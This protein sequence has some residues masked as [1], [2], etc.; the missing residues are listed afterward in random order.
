MLRP[1]NGAAVRGTIKVWL[2]VAASVAAGAWAA[3][4]VYNTGKALAEVSAQKDINGPVEW[5]ADRCRTT[6]FPGYFVASV[7][8]AVL[9]LAMPFALGLNRPGSVKPI[10]WDDQRWQWRRVSV[11]DMVVGFGWAAAP[12][13]VLGAFYSG[14]HWRP[15][16]AWMLAL[17]VG[18]ATVQEIL[19]RGVALGIFLRAMPAKWAMAV[20]A[21]LFALVHFLVPLPGVTVA[22]PDAERTGWEMLAKIFAQLAQPRVVLGGFVP[23]LALGWVLAAARVRT[24]ALWLSIGLHAGWIF[25]NS[26]V[27][28][29]AI[30]PW[31]AVWFPLAAILLGGWFTGVLSKPANDHFVCRI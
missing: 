28:S 6:E 14:F 18:I 30:L 5:L 26:M 7:A 22:D 4:L 15:A 24:N 27:V 3:P 12:V 1:M 23:M 21:L 31:S 13:L 8:M 2:Y 11:V 9:V 29:P 20:S 17:A 10:I 25:G 19:F 16:G